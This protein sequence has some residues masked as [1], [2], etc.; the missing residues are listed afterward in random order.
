MDNPDSLTR[1]DGLKGF[2]INGWEQYILSQVDGL[3]EIY[4]QT[5]NMNPA[6]AARTLVYLYNETM[7]AM[8]LN[9][10]LDKA[11]YYLKKLNVGWMKECMNNLSFWQ[12][13]ESCC[14]GIT[15]FTNEV[16]FPK[17]NFSLWLSWINE[18]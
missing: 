2:F 7:I 1:K 11:K 15:F 13:V 10:P 14:R 6:I 18:K 17:I 16:I 8:H 9:L 4:R 12:E 3:K 5:L